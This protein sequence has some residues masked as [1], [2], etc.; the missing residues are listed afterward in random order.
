MM[1]LSTCT[2]GG[3]KQDYLWEVQCEYAGRL[4]D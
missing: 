2:T 3:N 1:I 4:G